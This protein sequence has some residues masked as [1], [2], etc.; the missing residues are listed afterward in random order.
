MEKLVNLPTELILIIAYYLDELADL[1]SFLRVNR[2]LYNT[3]IVPFL[4]RETNSETIVT[5]LFYAAAYGNEASIRLLLRKSRVKVYKSDWSRVYYQGPGEPSQEVVN[6]VQT[7]R[8]RLR[9][10]HPNCTCGAHGPYEPLHWAIHVRSHRMAEMV[11][12]YGRGTC[13]DARDKGGRTA[14][15][16]AAQLGDVEMTKILLN[17]GAKLNGKRG[18]DTALQVA[19]NGDYKAVAK[20]LLEREAG[21]EKCVSWARVSTS[22]IYAKSYNPSLR[23]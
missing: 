7:K 22:S 8:L 20:I 2:C 6:F 17:H 19:A 12:N 16:R 14:L 1:N 10:G 5:A 9:L 11:L 21:L 4:L 13:V 3:L 23:F 15:Y 18:E